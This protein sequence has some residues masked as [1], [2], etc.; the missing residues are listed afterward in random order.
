MQSQNQISREY[1]VQSRDRAGGG[2][3]G[4]VFEERRKLSAR[5]CASSDESQEM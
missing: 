3:G 2:C 1:V 4:L 5:R